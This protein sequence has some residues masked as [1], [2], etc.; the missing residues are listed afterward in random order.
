MQCA[1]GAE[2]TFSCPHAP[3]GECVLTCGDGG[4]SVACDGGQ[5]ACNP[6]AGMCDTR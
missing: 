1:P 2:C 5:R 4:S 6:P 3:S